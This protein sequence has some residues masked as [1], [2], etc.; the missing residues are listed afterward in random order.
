MIV[1]FLVPLGLLVRS[2][3][4]DHATNAAIRE[5]ESLVPLVSTLDRAE[6]TLAVQQLSHDDS[7]D[8]PLTVFLPDH[9]QVGA[10]AEVSDAVRL[11]RSGRSVTAETEGGREAL[12]AAQGGPGGTTVIR[13]YVSS[14]Q[15]HSG[16]VKTWLILALLGLTLFVLSLVVADRLARSIIAPIHHLVAVTHRLAEG[17]LTARATVSGP[18]EVQDVAGGLNLLAGRIGELLTAE[19]EDVADLSHQLRTP[20]TAVRLGVESLPDP[21]DQARLGEAVGALERSVDQVIIQ[22]RRP[23]REG[24]GADCDAREVVVERLAFWSVLAEEEGR[25]VRSELAATAVRV[26]APSGD[27]AVAVDALLGNV[28]AHTP[29]GTG[30]T[31]ILR[32]AAGGGAVLTVHD[33]GPGFTDGGA[34][35]SRG[36]GSGASTGLGLDI[37]RRTALAAGGD[38]YAETAPTGGVRVTVTLSAPAQSRAGGRQP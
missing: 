13:A 38:M 5:A 31:V 11:S 37:V 22:A 29:E 21:D 1:A 35:L 2:V 32:A 19:R 16:V 24:V 28:F 3:A 30:F 9:T 27:L 26:R 15:L 14:Q 12:V 7:S 8:Y 23:V 18:P 4:A 17:D 10:P 34:G 36:E 25:E 6:L 33:D 20:L